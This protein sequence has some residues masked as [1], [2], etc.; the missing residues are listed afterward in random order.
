MFMYVLYPGHGAHFNEKI[1]P[2]VTKQVDINN[3]QDKSE[4]Y[5]VMN[6]SISYYLVKFRSHQ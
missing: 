5:K 3:F 4:S 1:F 6:E 2:V